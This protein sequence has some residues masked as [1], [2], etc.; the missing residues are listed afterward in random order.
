MKYIV[1]IFFFPKYI[2]ILLLGESENENLQSSN[3]MYSCGYELWWKN[4]FSSLESLKNLQK[5]YRTINS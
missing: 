4:Y 5:A 2:V 1:L 3:K